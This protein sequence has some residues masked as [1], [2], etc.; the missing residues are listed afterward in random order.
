[1]YKK[2]L[3]PLDGS[4]FSESVLK[5]VVAV[6]VGCSVPEVVLLTVMEP[7]RAMPY[8]AVEDW[9]KKLQKEAGEAADNYLNKTAENLASQGVSGATYELIEG[10]PAD[11][12]LDYAA[13]NEVDLIIMSTHGRSGVTRWVFGS[14]A[15]RVV[16]HS[17]VPVLAAPPSALS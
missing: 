17:P 7:L 16:R 11:V 9:L 3:V 8:Q 13:K 5:H 15:D 1:M 12:I 14:V 4:E 10:E 2:I 6:S